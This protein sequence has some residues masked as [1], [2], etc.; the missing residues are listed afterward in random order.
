MKTKE[1]IIKTEPRY[2]NDWSDKVDVV[3]DF[4][5]I[6]LSSK[7]YY[8]TESPYPNSTMWEEDVIKMNKALR[9][10]R[11]INILFAS[12][13][14]ENYSGDAWVLFE[15]D[16]KLYEVHGGHCSCYGL[17]GQWEPEEVSLKELENRLLNG[18]FGQDSYEGNSFKLELCEF[19]DIPYYIRK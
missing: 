14:Y 7:E 12:Y 1:E 10:Y 19:L 11:N 4:E 18:S 6:Y 3:G 8:A 2:L 17:E 9:L 15:E 13:G 16:G 5:N